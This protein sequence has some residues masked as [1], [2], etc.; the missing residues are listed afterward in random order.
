M[1]DDSLSLSRRCSIGDCGFDGLKG[2]LSTRSFGG[3]RGISAL[4]VL[5]WPREIRESGVVNQPISHVGVCFPV[6]YVDA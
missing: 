3:Q 1:R 5:G 4:V 6:I 2:K